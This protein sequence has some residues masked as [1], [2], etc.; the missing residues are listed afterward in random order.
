M[1]TQDRDDAPRTEPEAEPIV[2]W[3]VFSRARSEM[4]PGFI[5]MLGY[6]R[7][8]GEKS[9]AQ[10]EAAMRRKDSAALVTP[11]LTLSTEARQFGAEPLADVAEEIEGVARHCLEMR[12]TPEELLPSVAKLRPLYERTIAL[13]D[14]EA[15]PLQQRRPGSRG[16]DAANQF[17]R[18]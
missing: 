12:L 6:F 7:E 3:N 9:V 2:D 16:S 13:F 14:Q 5:R 11:A 10:I 17:G 8:D 18:L 4:G 1:W 15:N